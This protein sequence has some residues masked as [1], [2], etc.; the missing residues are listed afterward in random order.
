M[1]YP[2]E[3]PETPMTDDTEVMDDDLLFYSGVASMPKK[4]TEI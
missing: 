1:Q 3:Q 2:I 4:G